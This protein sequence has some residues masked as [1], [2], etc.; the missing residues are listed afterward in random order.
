[1]SSWEPFPRPITHH[2]H[3]GFDCNL[4]P[5]ATV[6]SPDQPPASE[7][8]S[9]SSV[10][11]SKLVRHLAHVHLTFC[12]LTLEYLLVCDSYLSTFIQI[13]Q[14]FSDPACAL[15]S[16]SHTFISVPQSSSHLYQLSRQSISSSSP[17]QFAGCHTH[18]AF[19]T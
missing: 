18:N 15:R 11:L 2:H 8:H 16:L 14:P 10:R 13:V 6:L 9:T 1:M 12:I 3:L 5:L 4:V 7:N 19:N 17:H